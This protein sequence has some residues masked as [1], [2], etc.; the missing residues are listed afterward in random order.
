MAAGGRFFTGRESVLTL[1]AE[2]GGMGSVEL[3]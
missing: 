2:L 1:K 3:R